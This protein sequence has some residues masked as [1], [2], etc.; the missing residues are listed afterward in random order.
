MVAVSPT[1][2]TDYD[3]CNLLYRLLPDNDAYD[4]GLAADTRISLS[5]LI[6]ALHN[7]PTSSRR[8][9]TL[10]MLFLS[11]LTSRSFLRPKVEFFCYVATACCAWWHDA[12]TLLLPGTWRCVWTPICSYEQMLNIAASERVLVPLCCKG[13]SNSHAERR[14]RNKW[15]LLILPR[16]LINNIAC[17]SIMMNAI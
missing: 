6:R 8:T 3:C 11:R 16:M 9:L 15:L 14:C 5:L 12:Y 13:N 2:S 1:L 17:F 4:V 7:A 10:L